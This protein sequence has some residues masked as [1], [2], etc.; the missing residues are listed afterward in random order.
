MTQIYD[1]L[2][3]LKLVSI[4]KPHI[5][6]LL[7][8]RELKPWVALNQNM[9]KTVQAL[10]YGQ[11]ISFVSIAYAF[12]FKAMDLGNIYFYYKPTNNSMGNTIQN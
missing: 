10:N 12:V 3:K 2:N 7:F 8:Y 5:S 9:S 1:I 6:F 4:E 11:F